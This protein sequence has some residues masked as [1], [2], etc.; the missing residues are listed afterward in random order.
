M[1]RNTFLVCLVWSLVV[2]GI[3]AVPWAFVDLQPNAN[4]TLVGFEWWTGNPGD[5]TLS[6]LPIGKEA[7]FEGPDGRVRFLVGPKA[8]VL[9]GTNAPKWPKEVK[10]I[11]VGG[12]A[13]AIYFLHATGWSFAGAPSYQF[14]LNYNDK[15]QSALDMIT[16]ENSRDW[17]HE[18]QVLNDKNSVWG[19]QL[20]EGPPCGHAGLIT[21][22]WNHPKPDKTIV[23][24]DAI[25]F[26]TAAVPILVAVTLGEATLSV[27]PRGNATLL[28]GAL[29]KP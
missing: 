18:G 5:S 8:I 4:S 21:T 28:W 24:L 2:P 1:R 6:R 16:N 9:N 26:G 13:K 29:K 23:T 11:A 19:W 7:E 3:R 25:S 22:K 12:K 15:T 27:S 10:G 20:K 14:V 17:Y